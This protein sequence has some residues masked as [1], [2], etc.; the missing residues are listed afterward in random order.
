M[1]TLR[2]LSQMTL[3]NWL[4]ASTADVRSGVLVDLQSKAEFPVRE[5]VHFVKLEAG[6][7]TEKLLAKVKTTA[8][9]EALGAEHC[10]TAV[11]LGE[12]VYEVVPGWLAEEPAGA[13]A[14]VKA[15]PVEPKAVA[16]VPVEPKTVA[17]AP[18]PK[19]KPEGRNTDA[20]MLAKLLLDK[21]S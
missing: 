17:P 11:I 3:D 16:A 19:Q 5:A 4:E 6:D 10:L 1:A 9:L 21:L 14:A 2:F 8:Q 20:E 15:A 7:D 18:V 13:A 12:T